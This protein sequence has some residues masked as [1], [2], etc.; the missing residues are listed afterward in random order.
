LEK[1][2]V[3][4]QKSYINRHIEV[5]EDF[6]KLLGYYCAEGNPLGK[7]SGIELSFHSKEVD[8]HSEVVY[9][10]KECF[11]AS[12]QVTQRHSKHVTTVRACNCLL[13]QLFVSLVGRGSHNKIIPEIILRSSKSVIQ[14]FLNGYINGDGHSNEDI[15]S[16]TT[17]S[18]SLAR[19]FQSLLL[20]QGEVCSFN[21]DKIRLD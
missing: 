10:I 7:N 4:I 5:N 11:G 15:V 9:L 6:A 18:E 2:D 13:S 16:I 8:Y 14:A 17:A 19:E 21:Q 3:G 12:A 1:H 20:D